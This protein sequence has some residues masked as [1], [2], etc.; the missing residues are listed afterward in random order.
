MP[1]TTPTLKI[2]Y[3]LD[4]DPLR[5][6]PQLAKDAA[7]A[8]EK[9]CTPSTAQAPVFDGGWQ[10][11]GRGGKITSLGALH[12][13]ELEIIRTA[14]DFDRANSEVDICTIPSSVP[15]PNTSNNAWT[16]IGMVSGMDSYPMALVLV[17]RTVKIRI[18]HQTHFTQN[19]RFYGQGIW[20][21]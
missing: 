19:W 9:Q 21:A 3:P 14:F 11:D 20:I 13:I 5:N 7:T 12:I 6:F 17:G 16:P 10:W 1:A 15:V 2:P 4:S 18:D 8:I